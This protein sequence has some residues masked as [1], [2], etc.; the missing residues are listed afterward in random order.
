MDKFMKMALLAC[1]FLFAMGQAIADSLSD[2]QQAYFTG[3]YAKAE[4]LFRLLAAQGNASAQAGLGLMYGLGLGVE[5]DTV[6][7]EKWFRL[8]VEKRHAL[9]Q[10][11]SDRF[12]RDT[13]ITRF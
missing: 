6:E 7:A 11:N 13:Y 10:R 8:A 9:I 3:D 4:K 2:A 12:Q 1:V 5:K